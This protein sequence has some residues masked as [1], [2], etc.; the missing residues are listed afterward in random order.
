MHRG[1]ETPAL[2]L[3]GDVIG[4]KYVVEGKLSAG[5]MGVILKARH[6]ALEQSVALKILQVDVAPTPTAI[7]RFA[8]EARAAAKI[9]GEH[10]VHIYDVGTLDNGTPF[11]VMELLEGSDLGTVLTARGQLEVAEVAD[12][13]VQTCQA[14]AQAHKLGIVHRDLKPQNVFI[15]L[16]PDGTPLVKLLDF[17]IS[18]LPTSDGADLTTTQAML[19]T[20]SYM[21][22]EQLLS[23]KDVDGR[24]D[25]WSLG[26]LMYRMLAGSPPFHADSMPEL[27][28]RILATPASPLATKR[29]NLP[30]EIQRIVH[31]CLEVRAEDRF[32]T[33]AEL[34]GALAPFGPGRCMDTLQQIVAIGAGVMSMR[35][36]SS[37]T[38]PS[39]SSPALPPPMNSLDTTLGIVTSSPRST[40]SRAGFAVAV[41][42]SGTAIVVAS[43]VVPGWRA[44][45]P[46]AAGASAATGAGSSPSSL[47]L[48]P[49]PAVLETS[50]APA[51]VSP[52]TPVVAPSRGSLGA[53]SVRAAKPNA[54][55]AATRAAPATARTAA[56]AP[57]S[58]TPGLHPE[59]RAS[60]SAEEFPT[61]R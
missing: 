47:V 54:K 5:G 46:P 3:P 37:P 24:S 57:S 34:A 23:A 30:E 43:F 14:L 40:R 21:S 33:V 55:A 59:A 45:Q 4:G 13:V 36:P 15:T 60:D 18:K 11:I 44:S 31:A 49:P 9:R 53:D 22:P 19:G 48:V 38:L 16:R 27:C 7:E 6:P 2:P 12:Y 56:P 17:G 39:P 20:P 58:P 8:R 28:A 32:Q 29:A 52:S 25:I 50:A 41:V 42:V 10:V 51:L 35:P 26:V 1:P 61:E